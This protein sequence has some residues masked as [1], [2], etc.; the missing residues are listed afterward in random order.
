MDT[1]NNK[2]IGFVLKG[3]TFDSFNYK[4]PTYDTVPAGYYV[5]EVMHVKETHSKNGDDAITV[6]YKVNPY[7]DVCKKVNG[8]LPADMEI[9]TYY[10]KQLYK[11]DS[12][13]YYDFIDS[14]TVALGLPDR[15]DVD[16]EAIIGVIERVKIGYFEW[17]DIGGFTFRD[18]LFEG[19]LKLPESNDN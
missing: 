5:S 12:D 14:M 2:P 17:T 19:D 8:V 4:Y 11:V 18:P 7:G 16:S 1:S 3:Y 6:Y 15:S 9:K 13:Y 10:I